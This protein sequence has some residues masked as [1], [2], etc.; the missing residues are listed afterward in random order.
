MDANPP[1]PVV[2]SQRQLAVIMFTDAVGFS[3][4]MHEQ[5]IATLNRIE[6]DREVMQ[7]IFDGHSGTVLKST[8]DGQ[9]VQFGSAVQAVAS[10]QEIQRHFVGRTD[11][12]YA[13]SALRYRI[14][15]HLG[16]VFVGNGDVMGDGVNIAARLVDLATPNG[17]VISETV[18]EVVK[19]KL[20]LHVQR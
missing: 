6:R 18:Y 20:P 4:K 19:N 1:F 8:G 5:E 12:A 13:E 15:V 11:P 14:S 16:D 7:R 9:L 10:A 17:I 3:A 2:S